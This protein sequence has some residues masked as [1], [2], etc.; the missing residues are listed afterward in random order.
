MSHIPVLLEEVV[1]GL[2]VKPGGLYID[3]TVGEG[4]HA[5][6]ILEAS[7]PDG[8]LLGI[9][10]DDKALEKASEKLARFRGRVALVKANYRDLAITARR[11]GFFQVDGIL[12]DLGFAF[13]QV[14][15]P[16]RGFSFYLNGPLDMRYD[17]SSKLSAY[18]IVNR[19]PEEELADIIWRYGEEPRAR[20]IARAIVQARPIRSTLE[21]AKV[22]EQ[23]VGS[24]RKIHP[25]TR[26]FQAIRIA[27]NQELDNLKEAL[28]QT[29]ELLKPG[30]RLAVISFHSLED[31]IV[32]EFFRQESRDCICPPE[33]PVCVCG[34][35]ATLKVI[36]AKPVKPS[37]EEVKANP[38][39]R[40]AKLRI[41]ERRP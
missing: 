3:A 15:D 6:A 21:L 27:V 28:P 34:H 19:T 8:C 25:A 24:G 38:R 30:G 18:H 37:P 32:K 17:R 10:A 11:E 9:D 12:F 13:F 41:A 5:E 16:Q 23:V 39:S 33:M 26:V 20:R 14:E 35:R 2:A 7:S 4:G 29:I 31:R 22:V 1:K 36:T 40:S